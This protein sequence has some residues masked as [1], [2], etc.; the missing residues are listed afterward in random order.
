M[1]FDVDHFDF[2]TLTSMTFQGTW[3]LIQADT[4]ISPQTEMFSKEAICRVYQQ[5]TGN[6]VMYRAIIT[7][8]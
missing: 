2:V 5:N 8:D 3:A 6:I 1:V 7:I 4:G